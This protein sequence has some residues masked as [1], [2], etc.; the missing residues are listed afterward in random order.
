MARSP[1]IPRPIP[2]GRAFAG[3]AAFP[4]PATTTIAKSR[5]RTW[6]WHEGAGTAGCS[7]GGVLAAAAG[8]STRWP[9]GTACS[10][11]P[12]CC[13]ADWP[14]AAGRCRLHS[15]VFIPG[16]WAAA[17]SVFWQK[18]LRPLLTDPSRPACCA[19]WIGSGSHGLHGAGVPCR[20]QRDTGVRVQ[21]AKAALSE[22]MYLL[23]TRAPAAR[24]A[25][26]ALRSADRIKTM[27]QFVQT[28]YAEDL[29]VE[30]IAASASISPQRVP[31]LP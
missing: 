18:Y 6:H 23:V 7:E 17:D 4:S 25:Q 13:G 11:M 16:W 28:H 10:S 20:G 14:L 2:L 21:D 26:K 15:V 19:A 8:K 3:T 30:Q 22:M 31:V 24:R 1:A 27:L 9:R 5:P 12:G 29:T